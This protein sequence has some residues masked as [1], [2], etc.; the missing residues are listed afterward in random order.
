MSLRLGSAVAAWLV[1]A[2]RRRR[3][4]ERDL[5]TLGIG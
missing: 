5:F 1:P 2:L 3:F 4:E